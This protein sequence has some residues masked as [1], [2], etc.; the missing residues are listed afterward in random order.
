MEI[1]KQL[2]PS[3]ITKNGYY[4]DV[5][6]TNMFLLTDEEI[7]AMRNY[8]ND[9]SIASSRAKKQRENRNYKVAKNQR[10][11]DGK[12]TAR[13]T[14]K[15]NPCGYKF[16]V[17]GGLIVAVTVYSMS[18]LASTFNTPVIEEQTYQLQEEVRL[19]PVNLSNMELADEA[20]RSL[21]LNTNLTSSS[22]EEV[23]N[24]NVVLVS[25]IIDENKERKEWVQKYC[26]IYQVNFDVTY[27]RLV[28]ITNNFTDSEYLN[29]HIPGVTC[30]GVE[31]FASSEEELILYYVRCVKQ[32][33]LSLG[34]SADNLYIHND[35]V[36]A[37]DYASMIGYYNNLVGADPVL[38]Y[39]IT[40]AETSWNSDLFRD[41]NN[42]AGLRINGSWWRF[43]TKEEGF[44]EL[45][46]E[47]LKFNRMGAYTIEEIGA[48]HAPVEDNNENWIPN[49]TDAYTMVSADTELL[50]ILQSSPE[51]GFTR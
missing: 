38:S 44:I 27:N 46:L 28:E 9:P 34:I 8:Y 10:Y 2:D 35:Y 49:V 47:I 5:D 20:I 50:E 40:Q 12:H 42:P 24:E 3:K 6:G 32:K 25:S 1:I 23:L 18:L 31:V 51:K 13:K 48:I 33:P 43:D 30:K 39:A 36:S 17:V 4:F 26:D 21:S 45:A 37:D 41:S 19:E 11:S 15:K 29:G 16:V 14:S 7:L 22:P